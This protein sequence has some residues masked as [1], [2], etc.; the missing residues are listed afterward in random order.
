MQA[1][2]LSAL[3][4]VASWVLTFK[5]A[6]WPDYKRQGKSEYI[7]NCTLFCGLKGTS[8]KKKKIRNAKVNHL[9]IFEKFRVR[10]FVVKQNII[11]YFVLFINLVEL[12]P[13]RNTGDIQFQARVNEVV[14]FI[15][16]IY[17]F[18]YRKVDVLYD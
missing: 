3:L 1:Y 5:L 16:F 2:V 10:I 17:I 7:I 6:I 13:G 12:W 11:Y 15:F 9:N 18:F 8:N 4:L 14:F